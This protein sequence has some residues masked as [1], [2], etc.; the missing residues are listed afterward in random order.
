VNSRFLLI[1]VL[2]ASLITTTA[3]FMVVFAIQA[4]KLNLTPTQE[5]VT[6]LILGCL[7]GGMA[8]W[9]MFRKLQ[10][11]YTKREARLT[12]ITLAVFTPV[13]LLGAVFLAEITGGFAA[14]LWNPL[15]LVGAFAG[16]VLVTA[17]LNSGPCML[18]SWLARRAG[19]RPA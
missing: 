3:A 6:G 13:S 19:K 12:A 4:L 7:P 17:A 1:Q 2:K 14:S 16:T 18:V 9:W 5:E 10:T 11:R 15:G 8:A